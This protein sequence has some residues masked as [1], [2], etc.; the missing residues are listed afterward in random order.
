MSSP[1]ILLSQFNDIVCNHT[2]LSDIF[3]QPLSKEYLE[4]SFAITIRP[5][6][7][8]VLGLIGNMAQNGGLGCSSLSF[9]EESKM[10]SIPFEFFKCL[11]PCSITSRTVLQMY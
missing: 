8:H 10:K 5:E 7:V 1:A 9:T 4:F 6:A 3:H 11:V 2:F